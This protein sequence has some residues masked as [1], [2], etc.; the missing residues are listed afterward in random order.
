MND[1]YK[2]LRNLFLGLC[3]LKKSPKDLPESK[4]L[5]Q[6]SGFIYFIAGAILISSDA[7]LVEALAQAFIEA[8]LVA[9]F[10]YGLTQFFSVPYRFTQAITAIYGSGTIITALSIPFVFWLQ[11]QATNVESTGFSG[12]ILLLIVCWSFVVMA[13]IIRETIQKNLAISLLLTFCYLYL[14]YQVINVLY[15]V[16]AL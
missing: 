16:E 10:V 3:L 15:P 5:L 12:L 9:L 2:T 7:T 13:H 14:S 6:M 4:A 11:L 1:D 8:L